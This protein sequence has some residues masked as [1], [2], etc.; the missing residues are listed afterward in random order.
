MHDPTQCVWWSFCRWGHLV[1]LESFRNDFTGQLPEQSDQCRFV[2]A[3]PDPCTSSCSCSLAKHIA[4][5]YLCTS[6]SREFNAYNKHITLPVQHQCGA[7]ATC[8]ALMPLLSQCCINFLWLGCWHGTLVG[9]LQTTVGL[10]LC[11]CCCSWDCCGLAQLVCQ[12]L[13]QALGAICKMWV[14]AKRLSWLSVQHVS[15]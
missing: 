14:Q 8:M 12:A 3:A 5:A 2:T 4:C 6:Q 15:V 7:V 10:S 9:L 13:Y 11:N 1:S